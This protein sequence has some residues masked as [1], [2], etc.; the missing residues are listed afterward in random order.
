MGG[1][2]REDVTHS[3]FRFL[4]VG[5]DSLCYPKGIGKGE[6][7][8]P[9]TKSKQHRKVSKRV[10]KVSQPPPQ[11]ALLKCDLC[12]KEF[13]NLAGVKGHQA[14]T[15]GLKKPPKV[16]LREKFALIDQRLS[17]V[18]GRSKALEM[19]RMQQ[20]LGAGSPSVGQLAEALARWS[21]GSCGSEQ[22]AFREV[23]RGFLGLE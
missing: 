19:A 8:M 1:V 21:V 3:S 23:M 16:G 20:P 9:K 13:K 22:R 10:A 17:I 11:K 18:E 14:V 2:E 12:G 4:G 15:H 7:K 6:E 5:V